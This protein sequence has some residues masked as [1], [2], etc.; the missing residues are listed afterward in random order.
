VNKDDQGT[1]ASF[2]CVNEARF[3]KLFFFQ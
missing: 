2:I 1:A 3:G